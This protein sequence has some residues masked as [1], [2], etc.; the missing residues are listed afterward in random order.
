MIDLEK[1]QNI[2]FVGIAGIG[3]S[4]M[5]RMM[6]SRGKRVTGNDIGDFDMNHALEK[7]G[8]PIEVGKTEES[9]PEDAELVVYSVAWNDLCPELLKAVRM[10]RVPILSYPEMLKIVSEDMYTI[11]VSGTHGKTT[12]TAMIAKV[13]RDGGLDPTVIVGSLL[14]PEDLGQPEFVG[15]RVLRGTNF[16]AGES[17]YL[18]VEADEY[19]KSF[20]SLSPQILVITNIDEDHLDFFKDLS[21]IQEAFAELVRKIPADGALV[22]NP[23]DPHV[24]PILGEAKCH[25]LSYAEL[26]P[27]SYKLRV[28]GRHNVSNAQAADVVGDF[29]GIP[30]DV[31]ARSLESFSGTWRRFDFVGETSAGVLV[32]DDY[33]HNP[34]KVRAALSGAREMYPDREITVVFQPH[35]YSRTKALFAEFG[36][37]FHD[38]NHVI[39][40]PIYAAREQYDPSITGDML[41]AEISKRHADAAFLDNFDKIET[42]LL[43]RAK[44][45]SVVIT[46]G[47][48]DI[49]KLAESFVQK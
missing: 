46:M 45:G 37:S 14:K 20:L 27:F 40:A 8:I 21:G 6:H 2:H 30:R 26:A 3:I 25:V 5:A 22:C 38:A 39:I 44:T 4:A 7:L 28:P 43:T 48:G 33:A 42:R 23:D 9:I 31:R 13:L 29:L 15:A 16:I 36:K 32:Y 11:A 18:V 35:L 10:R 41:A 34:H 19:R 47:A 12:T 24:A 1:I 17:D 49:C